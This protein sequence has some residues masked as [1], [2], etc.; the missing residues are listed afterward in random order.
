MLLCPICGAQLLAM[1]DEFQI[2]ATAVANKNTPVAGLAAFRCDLD[3]HIVF[4]RRS[5]LPVAMTK[6]ATAAATKR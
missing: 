6:A 3:G 4:I 1:L 2:T 5:D